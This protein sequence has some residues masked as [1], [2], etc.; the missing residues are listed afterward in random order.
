MTLVILH[1]IVSILVVN[2]I[3]ESKNLFNYYYSFFF[4][5]GKG[6]SQA[7]LSLWNNMLEPVGGKQFAWH[8]GEGIKCPTEQYPY[9]F[10]S[11]N[12]AAALEEYKRST[13]AL[14]TDRISSV[15]SSSNA[16]DVSSTAKHKHHKDSDSF[17]KMHFTVYAGFFFLFL[18]LL[19]V[20][21]NRRQ[22]IRVF[23]NGTG[24]RHINGFNNP[25]YPDDDD[26]NVEIW[27]RPNKKS[28]LSVNSDL[29]KTHGTRITFE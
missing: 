25:Q 8:M 11:N 13:M 14:I 10:T 18:M 17:N 7:A 29:P 5:L 3:I 6:H 21:I 28:G 16:P 15:P 19:I 4:F 1:P 27:N 9:I 23:I 12:S 22:Q 26:D 24:K 20:S 2:K